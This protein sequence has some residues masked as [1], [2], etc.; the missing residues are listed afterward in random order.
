MDYFDDGEYHEFF[1]NKEW[2]KRAK[3]RFGGGAGSGGT[4]PAP[5]K[6]PQPIPLVA[7]EPK[8]GLSIH[9]RGMIAIGG[10]LVASV[11]AF[12]LIKKFRRGK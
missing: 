2:F 5:V 10:V 12:V 11:V 1:A 4:A 7:K 6:T 8:A 3:K 9:K